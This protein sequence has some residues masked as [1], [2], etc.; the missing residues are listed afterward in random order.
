MVLKHLDTFLATILGMATVLYLTQHGGLGISPDSIYYISAAH[1]LREGHGFMQFDDTPFVL[2][3]LVYPSFL[4]LVELISAND[5]VIMAPY[6][7]A[8]LFGTTIFLSGTMLEKMNL[9]KLVKWFLLAFIALSPSLLEI[10]TMLWSEALFITEILL[11]IWVCFYYFEN[12]SLKNLILL[13]LIAAIAADTRLAGVTIIAT[14][15]L[16]I[17][18]SH[19]SKGWPKWKHIILYSIISSSLLGINL[20]RNFLVATSFTG[21]RQKGDTSF[22]TNVKYFG[23][24]IGSWLLL[25]KIPFFNALWMGLFFIIGITSIFLYRYL[26]NKEHNSFEKIAACFTLVYSLFMLLSATFSKYETINNRLLAP[27]FIPLLF[28]I[29]FYIISFIQWLQQPRWKYMFIGLFAFAGLF[30]VISYY[31]AAVAMQAEN[32][33]GGIGGYG[34]DGWV[35]SDLLATLKKESQYFNMGIPVYSNASHAV[36]FFTK[37]HLSILPETKHANDLQKFYQLPQNILI[38][39][40]NEENPAIESLEQINKH[41]NLTV[42]KQCKD[43]FIFLCTP[44]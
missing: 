34:E 6:L 14:G 16:L 31:K 32:K 33:E 19:D 39:L 42:L 37:R 38:W 12:S 26:K 18:L 11:F 9:R 3:P 17:L 22:L 30:S 10:Y 24:V 41:K 1:S 7:N 36:Y 27:F 43:G 23:E 13:A 44:K 8:L 21:A 15:G 28:T 20:L 5:I 25:Y 2:F 35:Y 4:A 40:N 29:G